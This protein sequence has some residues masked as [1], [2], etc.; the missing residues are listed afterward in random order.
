MDCLNEE[1]ELVSSARLGEHCGQGMNG[2]L[3]MNEMWVLLDKLNEGQ[4][5]VGG[6]SRAEGLSDHKRVEKT[7]ACERSE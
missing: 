7:V 3:G 6:G 2:V 4:G 5:R 1:L